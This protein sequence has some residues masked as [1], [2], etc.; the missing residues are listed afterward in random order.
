[1][2]AY[3]VNTLEKVLRDGNADRETTRIL[4]AGFLDTFYMNPD[5]RQGMIDAEPGI[6]GDHKTDAY[7]GAVGEY[8]ARRWDLRVPA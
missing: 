3:R 2:T 4:F 6:T 5:R 1:M 7:M 8:L